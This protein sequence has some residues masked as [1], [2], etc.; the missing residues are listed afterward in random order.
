MPI[1][2]KILYLVTK[3]NYGGGQKYVLELA[4]AAKK[5]GYFVTV[6]CGGTGKAGAGT[7]VLV[8][9]LN[10]K[11]IPVVKVEN[12]M[13]DMSFL[14]DLLAFFEVWKII[15]NQKPDILHV[16]SSKAGGI[17]ALA[18]R[19]AGTKNI[20][21]TSHGLTID[22][23]WRPRWQ[24]ILIYIGTWLTIKLAH[25]SI[26]ISIETY[27]R[28]KNMPGL[29]DKIFLVKN[30]IAPIDFLDKPKARKSL[31]EAIP[32]KGFWVGGIG[33]LHPNKNWSAAIEAM[34]T[35]PV[36]I[37]LIIIGEGEE[38]ANLEKLIQSKNLQNRVHL[39]GF[40]DNA[41]G[42]LRAFDAFILV[43]KKE[44]LPYVLL[45]AGLASLP[46]IASDLPGN[47][48]IIETGKNGFLIEPTPK[49]IST[50]VET[51]FRDEGMR[52][53]LGQSLHET[54]QKDFSIDNMSSQTFSV[55]DSSRSEA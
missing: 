51:L 33:E 9:K 17:G 30:G 10:K 53:T 36:K 24:R 19:L 4:E 37:H 34:A 46:T 54:I 32:P 5:S 49:M 41:S 40:I 26:M 6:A 25:K 35:L 22:E 47:H 52:R 27:E 48:D 18:G 42:Y 14:S 28:A 29:A 23:V 13:R 21:F 12:F 20:I 55:Y 16:N 2:Q 31:S 43:S 11:S 7:G 8:E 39:L 45:E 38:R 44:G 1:N 3:S 15:R 50:T